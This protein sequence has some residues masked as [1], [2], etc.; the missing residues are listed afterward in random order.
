MQ[1]ACDTFCVGDER[2]LRD[3]AGDLSKTDHSWS[4]DKFRIT[5]ANGEKDIDTIDGE[6][7][8][9]KSS[10]LIGLTEDDDERSIQ[11]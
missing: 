11:V 4:P 3:A 2:T 10:L 5:P 7:D 8:I 1:A 6:Y 9:S